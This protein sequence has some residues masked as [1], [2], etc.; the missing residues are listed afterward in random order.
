[1]APRSAQNNH[2]D[3]VGLHGQDHQSKGSGSGVKSKDG[4]AE[5]P[6]PRKLMLCASLW[7]ME[8]SADF[9]HLYQVP[10]SKRMET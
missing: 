4:T 9:E 10:V 3:Q 5:M 8:A 1:M 6:L 2:K 7:G